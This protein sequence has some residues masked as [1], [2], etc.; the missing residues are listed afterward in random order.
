MTAKRQPGVLCSWPRRLTA[1][2]KIGEGEARSGKCE[3]PG[4]GTAKAASAKLQFEAFSKEPLS[5]TASSRS[6]GGKRRSR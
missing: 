5:A 3:P 2:S 4:I 6:G 1:G